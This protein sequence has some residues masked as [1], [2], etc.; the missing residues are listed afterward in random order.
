MHKIIY[1]KGD[2][3]YIESDR[4]EELFEKIQ[5]R[6]FIMVGENIRDSITIKSVV[7]MSDEEIMIFELLKKENPYINRKVN[8]ELRVYLKELTPA[9]VK[10]MILKYKK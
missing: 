4:I 9:V 2:I 6:Q 10:N 1:T 3:D 8:E 5:K 7:K